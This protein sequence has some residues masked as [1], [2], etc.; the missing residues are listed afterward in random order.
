[1]SALTFNL[2]NHLPYARQVDC[3]AEIDLCSFPALNDL[4]GVTHKAVVRIAPDVSEG[5]TGAW[6]WERFAALPQNRRL[7]DDEDDLYEEEEDEDFFEDDEDFDDEDDLF[8]DDED[9]EEDEDF[10]DEDDE[11]IDEDD[12]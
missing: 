1:M 2:H 4:D 9:F 8:D 3:R 12:L 7:D 6:D 5:L 10:F 11:D